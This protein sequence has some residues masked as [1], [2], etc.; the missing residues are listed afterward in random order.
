MTIRSAQP[1]RSSRDCSR[2]PSVPGGGLGTL[3]RRVPTQLVRGGLMTA[4]GA[5]PSDAL[6]AAAVQAGKDPWGKDV[7]WCY[8]PRGKEVDV[9]AT[10]ARLV[11]MLTAPQ[12]KVGDADITEHGGDCDSKAVECANLGVPSEFY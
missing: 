8:K 2:L 5:A 3:T 6:Y 4:L 1:G 9:A 10:E 7:P 12:L 11:L